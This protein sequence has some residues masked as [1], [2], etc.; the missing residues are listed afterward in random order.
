MHFLDGI[1]A[2][3]QSSE[4]SSAA[5]KCHNFIKTMRTSDVEAL[6]NSDMGC[7]QSG[8]QLSTAVFRPDRPRAEMFKQTTLFGLFAF[9]PFT[10]SLQ[11]QRADSNIPIPAALSYAGNCQ[12][13]L[14]KSRLTR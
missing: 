4:Q 10:V 1:V 3:N 6:Q 14:Q 12:I 9:P 11:P 5:F 7:T 8:H 13:L 2:A